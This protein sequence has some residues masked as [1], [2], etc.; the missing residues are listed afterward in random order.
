MVE[1]VD[2]LIVGGG[3]MGAAAAWQLSR[4]ADAR[5]G[6]PK[7]LL[8]EQFVRGHTRGSSHGAS[9]IFRYT[10]HVA[11][12]AAMMPGLLTSWRALEAEA[13]EPLFQSCGGLYIGRYPA[14]PF[15]A[16]CVDVLQAQ[17]MEYELLTPAETAR[18][19]PQF[20]LRADEAALLQPDNAIVAASPAVE[21]MGRLAQARGIE[22]RDGCRVTA[23]EPGAD[24]LE[25]VYARDGE[26]MRVRAA[27]VILTV[28]PWAPQLL[29]ALLPTFPPLPL[30]VTRQQ[31]AYF[32]VEDQEAWRVARCPLFIYT[33][34]PHVYG[35]PIHERAGQIKVA[36]ELHDTQ[37]SPDDEPSA[38][39]WAVAE[40]EA[41]VGE[42]LVG[43]APRALDVTP[44]LYT[45]TPTRDFIVDRHPQWPG[46]VIAAG[47]SGRGF[48]FAPGIG[49][50]AAELALGDG[51]P[52]D[53]PLWLPQW[54]LARFGD[55]APAPAARDFE[56]FGG[57]PPPA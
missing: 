47:F 26:S 25:V 44:C 48:K 17:G 50:L 6:A 4:R 55:G 41:T 1:E 49:A 57:S 13:N 20:R 34:D 3:V 8:L 12:E 46:L 53:S 9:R 43:V 18:R 51:A 39:A 33:A 37:V 15:L 56:L 11:N 21:A 28:G 19:Y 23:I 5:E 30:Q 42:R 10:H 36:R 35:F 32:N 7:V 54:N 31:V 52:A 45:E 40:L 38:L 24:G 14:D 16:A 2:I 29:G 27:R 22:W